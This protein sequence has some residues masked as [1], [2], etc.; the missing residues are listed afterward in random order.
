MGQE[1][2]ASMK[3][4][5]QTRYDTQTLRR[6]LVAVYRDVARTRGP[7][8]TWGRLTVTVVT[9]NGE[10]R[11]IPYGGNAS[12]NG[13]RMRLRLPTPKFEVRR[14][15]PL[16]RHELWHNYGV[17]HRDYPPGILDCILSDADCEVMESIGLGAIGAEVSVTE[18]TKVE[19][20]VVGERYEG[21][22]ER[23]IAWA[24]KLKRAQKALT[25]IRTQKRYYERKMAARTGLKDGAS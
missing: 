15:V 6:I 9:A 21:L 3:L 19:R 8:D 17:K 24:S 12:F 18:R 2:T 10:R 1:E 11:N 23:E 16:V 20:D 22:V 7:L 5:N 4:N 13:L 25:K 14:L